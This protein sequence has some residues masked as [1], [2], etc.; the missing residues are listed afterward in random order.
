ML[1][2]GQFYLLEN[3]KKNL[4]ESIYS[5]AD[6]EQGNLSKSIGNKTVR[7]FQFVYIFFIWTQM[8]ASCCQRDS[9]RVRQSQN[10]FSSQRFFQKT[11]KTNG[12]YYYDT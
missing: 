3:P 10:D 2:L 11:N 8:Y 12:L 5:K 4:I 7:G 1:R 9:L 6:L